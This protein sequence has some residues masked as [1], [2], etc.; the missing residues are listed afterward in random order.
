MRSREMVLRPA[1]LTIASA[2]DS[3]R[4]F[5]PIPSLLFFAESAMTSQGQKE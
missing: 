4:I 2:I 3:F 1:L 5:D